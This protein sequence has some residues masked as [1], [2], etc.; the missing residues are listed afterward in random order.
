MIIGMNIEII[1]SL[2]ELIVITA[3]SNA[4]GTLKTIFVSKKYLKPVYITTFLDAIVFGTIMKKITSGE[5]FYL[6]IAFAIGKVLGAWL[7]DFLDNKLALGILEIDI[8]LNHFEKMKDIAD[9]LRDLG[10]STETSVSFGYKG[11]KRYKINVTML[12]KEIPILR[13]ILAKYEYPDPTMRIKEISNINGK[14]SISCA[15]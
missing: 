6:I 2:L 3:L 5:E 7:G 10:Y 11:K 1:I 8:Y 13:E 14:I 15:S 12:R 9:E 4:I